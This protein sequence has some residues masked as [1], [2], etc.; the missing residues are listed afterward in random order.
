[1]LTSFENRRVYLPIRAGDDWQE[2][3][4]SDFQD[5]DLV[6]AKGTKVHAWWCPHDGSDQA[7]LY[8]HGNAGN[9]SH[10]GPSMVKVR[11]FLRMN[12]LIIDYPGYGKSEGSP[13]EMGCY[14]AADAAY[15]WLV[16]QKRI[17]PER[18]ILYGVSLGGGVAVDLASRKEHAALVLVKTF[19]SIPDVGQYWYP[20]LPVRW[21]ARNRFNSL[22]KIEF[23]QRPIFIAGSLDDQL[24]PFA[25]GK[26]LFDA[27]NEPKEFFTLQGGHNQGLPKEF[28]DSLQAF[29]QRH[30]NRGP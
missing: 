2:P 18:I 6:T 4:S 7:V 22:N 13:N 14:D 20:W 5:V 9:L 3:P 10:R 26:K 29:L 1:M 8:L 27:A 30:G 24:I 23:C 19:T 21:L 16:E 12:V 11:D 25:L 17:A 28:F 15:D